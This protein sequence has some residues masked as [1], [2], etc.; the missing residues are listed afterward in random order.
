[1]SNPFP[2]SPEVL[3]N[4]YLLLCQINCLHLLAWLV[5][6]VI[7]FRRQWSW[8]LILLIPLFYPFA[9]LVLALKRIRW[10][11]WIASIHG[12]LLCLWFA[13][14]VYLKSSEWH[15]LLAAEEALKARGELL[16]PTLLHDAPE[17]VPERPP[18]HRAAR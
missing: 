10:I 17:V 6:V 11:G 3:P 13:G 18:V 5:A 7:G 15:Q 8:G 14:G 4:Y 12:L 9:L 1:M 16:D 2:F